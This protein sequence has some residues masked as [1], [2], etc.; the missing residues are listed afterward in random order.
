VN[1]NRD[2]NKIKPSDR[3]SKTEERTNR[4]CLSTTQLFLAEHPL[5]VIQ[6]FSV[7]Q[8]GSECS[9]SKHCNRMP[10]RKT[11]KQYLA[12]PTG[13]SLPTTVNCSA[14]RHSP[15]AFWIGRSLAILCPSIHNLRHNPALETCVSQVVE[16]IVDIYSSEIH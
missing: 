12:V 15:L 7:I 1:F 9:G 2:I 14:S 3:V 13:L 16:E 10:V 11:V 4:M 8:M 6:K 5:P